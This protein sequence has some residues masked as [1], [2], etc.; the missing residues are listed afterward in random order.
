[1]A[2]ALAILVST[3]F[4]A[5]AQLAE[6]SPAMFS[7]LAREGW[8]A[9]RTRNMFVRSLTAR[10]GSLDDGDAVRAG[11]RTALQYEKLR[12]ATRELLPRALHGADVDTTAREIGYLAEAS[13]EV[14]LA[15]AR[16]YAEARFGPPKNV[17]GGPSTFVVI[18][19]GKLGGRELNAGSDVDLIYFYDTDEGGT[20]PSDGTEHLAPRLLVACRTALDGESRRADGR[21]RRVAR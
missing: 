3:A 13:L 7:D 19:M 6:S 11:L 9:E 17:D 5:I 12:I 14:A 21:R 16:H 18:G 20:A 8:R 2:A 4:P 15:E 1:M 10:A